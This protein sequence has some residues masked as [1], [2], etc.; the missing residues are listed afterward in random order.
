[1]LARSRGQ[2]FGELSR[3]CSRLALLLKFLDA[4]KT[5]LARVHPWD[6]QSRAGRVDG[7]VSVEG[8]GLRGSSRSV[9]VLTTP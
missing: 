2:M 9:S 4:S 6:A 7:R 8:S 1:M 5:L 3:H